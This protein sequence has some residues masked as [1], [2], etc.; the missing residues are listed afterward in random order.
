MP[1]ANCSIDRISCSRMAAIN[2][3]FQT[4]SLRWTSTTAAKA[5]PAMSPRPSASSNMSDKLAALRNKLERGPALGDFV[6]E[7]A[8]ISSAACGIPV[9]AAAVAPVT[10][11]S[12]TSREPPKPAWLKVSTPTGQLRDNF[13]RLQTSVKKLNLATVCEEAKCPNIGQCWGGREGT[14]TATI[15]L[16]GD[17]CT[18]GCYFCNVKTSRNPPPLDPAEPKRTAEAVVSWGLSYVVLTSVNRDDLVS[19]LCCVD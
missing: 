5:S 6:T 17:T 16:M 7:T 11:N 19:R 15:M 13:E 2:R 10:T 1:F 8:A 14:A 4:A 3:I 9:D 12:N 18:R